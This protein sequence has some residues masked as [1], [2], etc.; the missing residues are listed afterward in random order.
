MTEQKQQTTSAISDELESFL[1]AFKDREGNYK[2]FD[3][4]KIP[5]GH[6]MIAADSLG[7]PYETLVG[8]YYKTSA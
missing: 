3:K 4:I 8:H 1:R 5:C 7:V 6:A 2:Y